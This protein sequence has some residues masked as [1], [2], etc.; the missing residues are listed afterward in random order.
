[1]N[2]AR[3]AGL[4]ESTASAM[5]RFAQGQRLVRHFQ[6]HPHLQLRH[7]SSCR[8]QWAQAAIFPAQPSWRR[9]RAFS[10]RQPC[11]AMGPYPNSYVVVP[12]KGGHTIP[13]RPRRPRCPGAQIQQSSRLWNTGR[14]AC[15]LSAAVFRTTHRVQRKYSEATSLEGESTHRRGQLPLYDEHA[16]VEAVGAAAIVR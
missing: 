10:N 16:A 7:T 11:D 2:A 3:Q 14:A 12:L 4:I 6:V 5:L 1:M 8:P 15:A 13:V 9:V